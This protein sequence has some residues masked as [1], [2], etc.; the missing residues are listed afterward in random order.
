MS[1]LFSKDWIDM[2]FES[3]NKDYGA[4]VMRQSSDKRHIKALAIGFS[5][6]IIALSAPT[7]LSHIIPEEVEV[8][9]VTTE[10]SDI[11]LDAPK[12]E[13]E[14]KPLELPPP[15]ERSQMAYVAPVI[16]DKNV[17]DEIKTVEE[18][19]ES[20]V[21]IGTQDVKGD[22]DAPINL[23]DLDKDKGNIVAVPDPVF[24]AV[25]QQPA[26]PGGVEK[27]YEY[28]S[29]NINYPQNAIEMG[30]TG[31]VYVEFVVGKDGKI[32]DVKIK[33]GI[34]GGQELDK[35]AARVIRLMPAWNPGRQNGT[36]VSCK[37]LVPVK[38]KL[39]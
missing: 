31:T 30:I 27:L 21:Q 36:A 18:V 29:K 10:L 4:F 8:N 5:F 33:R 22:D 11:K 24:E 19:N 12:E 37:Y 25:E 34:S 23:D 32:R 17:D 13:E 14:Q 15:P 1:Q 26:F 3:K 20:K 39:N 16:T 28:L 2:V 9:D 38:F 7:V 35:E 6:F